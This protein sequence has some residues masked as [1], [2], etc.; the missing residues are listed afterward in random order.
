MEMKDCHRIHAALDSIGMR[1]S[2][3]GAGL[4]ALMREL[5][6]AGVLDGAAIGRI[7]EAIVAD[8]GVSRPR[9]T[10]HA[11]FEHM[12]R[13]RLDSLLPAPSPLNS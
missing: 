11:E 9:T 6:D 7:K 8:I 12:V 4:L 1:Q 13:L 2:G 3:T 5:R 10:S